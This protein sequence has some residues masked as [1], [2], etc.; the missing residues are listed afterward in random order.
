MRASSRRPSAPSSRSKP[1]H[2]QEAYGVLYVRSRYKTY[3]KIHI[4]SGF[5]DANRPDVRSRS[6]NELIEDYPL[7]RRIQ[8]TRRMEIN[9]LAEYFS[10]IWT[11]QD[12]GRMYLI[13][14]HREV[15]VLL[16]LLVRYLHK[17]A[18]YKDL[19]DVRI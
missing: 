18:A 1:E 7:G 10:M 5:D 16:S 11:S 15:R 12:T 9:N 14:L 13:I 4:P 19:P 6:Q 17:V 8:T 3:S 2:I